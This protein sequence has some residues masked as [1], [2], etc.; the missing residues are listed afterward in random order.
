MGYLQTVDMATQMEIKGVKN[1][2]HV[3]SET[4]DLISKQGYGKWLVR[5]EE[6]VVV[7]GKGKISTYFVRIDKE[8]SSPLSKAPAPTTSAMDKVRI[9]EIGKQHRLVDWTVEVLSGL[10]KKILARRQAMLKGPEESQDSIPTS[11]SSK[12]QMVLDE[13]QEVV[14][15]PEFRASALFRQDDPDTI[16]LD[17]EVVHELSNLMTA[18]AS[19]YR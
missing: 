1:E 16:Q 9:D 12:G 6:E 7:K 17:P 11:L 19:M 18:F 15:L 8:R 10:L 2:I 13:V 4:A 5:R 3:T 14:S